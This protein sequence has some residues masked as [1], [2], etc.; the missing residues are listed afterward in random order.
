MQI[1]QPRRMARPIPLTALVDVAFL[2]LMFFVLSTTFARFGIIGLGQ[3]AAAPGGAADQSL[4]A[5]LPGI[6]VDV[7]H[8]PAVR[9]N[10]RT[11]AL[12]GLAQ[13]LDAFEAR[14]L[15]SAIIRVRRDADVQDLV[16][17]LDTARLSRL[18]T[19]SVAR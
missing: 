14:G 5:P 12:A 2:L 13:A 3:P 10:G 19:L 15:D 16:S 8:G 18:R 7:F 6:I 17:V 4:A 1:D 9:V 11:V